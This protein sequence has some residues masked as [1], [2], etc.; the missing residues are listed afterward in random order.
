[1]AS[2]SLLLGGLVSDVSE[3]ALAEGKPQRQLPEL[4]ARVLLGANASLQSPA[5]GP[6]SSHFLVITPHPRSQP[7]QAS[8]NRK[9]WSVWAIFI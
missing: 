5:G 4:R 3:A 1:M 8:L 2:C 7:S 9:G 6:T